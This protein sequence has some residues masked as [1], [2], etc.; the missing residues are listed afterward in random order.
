MKIAFYGSSLLSAYWNGAAT[1]YRGLLGAL[2]EKGWDILFLEPDAFDR[3]QHRDIDPPEW[4][5]VVVWENSPQGCAAAMARAGDADVVV[6]ASG[7]GVFD[8]ELLGVFDRARDDA[9][10][11]YWDVDAPATLAEIRAAPDHPLRQVLPRIDHVLTYGGGSPVI[12]AFM[13]LGARDCRPIY[14]ALDPATHHPV[15]PDGRFSA[16]LALLANRL[17]DRESRIDRF[18]LEPAALSPE[19]RFLLG[20][21]GWGDKSMPANVRAVGHVGTGEHNAFNCT[22]LAVLNVARDSMAEIGFSPATRVFEATGAG[23]CLITDYWEG[24]DQFLKPDVEVLVA[25][26]GKDVADHL[27][28]LTPE[29]ARAIGE[30]A[31][32]RVLADH[33]YAKRAETVDALFRGALTARRERSAA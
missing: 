11:V 4:A 18:F 17:P 15:Q 23:A 27:A 5:E 1:Y 3:Q 29:R 31:R 2:A 16:D 6:K 8:H 10:T 12:E 26:D 14:N 20:G 30:A 22:P 33:T 25:R 7:V 19:R 9:L 13:A 24:V 28:A 21:S 32:V